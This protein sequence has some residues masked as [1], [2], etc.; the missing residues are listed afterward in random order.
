MVKK[1]RKQPNNQPTQI[2]GD[3]NV[4]ECVRVPNSVLFILTNHAAQQAVAFSHRIEDILMNL[5]DL[6]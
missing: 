4:R 5:E 3:T 2:P 1:R 6:I